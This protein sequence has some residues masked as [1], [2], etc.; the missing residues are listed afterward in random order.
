MLV[1]YV[2]DFKLA[3]PKDKLASAWKSLRS[4]V[5][6]GEPEPFDRYFGCMR[7]EF[8]QV[9]L[10]STAH[11]FAFVFDEKAAAAAAQH[12][13]QDW[14][15]HDVLRR[16][17]VRRHI[18]PRKRL[19]DPGD[20]GGFSANF[21]ADRITIFD[22]QVTMKACVG[23]A[24][25]TA[26]GGSVFVLDHWTEGR[27]S[28]P[29]THEFWTGRTI[30]TYG[31]DQ[32][33]ASFAVPSKNRPGPHRDKREAKKEA[34]AQRFKEVEN[35]VNKKAGVM[36]KPVNLVRYDDMT[37]HRSLNL[38]WKHTASLRR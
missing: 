37:W 5:N 17:W 9:K 30:F 1:V 33:P 24:A 12:R 31:E 13:T 8:N 25:S 11:P 27:Q 21:K 7:R 20:E 36:T 6:I 34:K 16:A 15:E 14:W 3:G 38:V 18:Q 35:A 22:S 26:E 23:I 2:D 4:A 19:F 29:M 28:Q 32:E 10:P